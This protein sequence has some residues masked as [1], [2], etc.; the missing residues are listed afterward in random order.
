MLS[1]VLVKEVKVSLRKTR[2]AI[3]LI[4]FLGAGFLATW[5]LWP[6]EGI[7]TLSAQSSHNLFTVLAMG[8]LA[9]VALFAPAF[10]A[11]ALTVEKERNTLEGLYAT[12]LTS[13]DIVLGK[14]GGSLTFLLLVILAGVPVTSTCL[15]LGGV[16]TADVVWMYAIIFLTAL[17]YGLLGLML[18]SLCN[19]TQRA[20]MLTYVLI[21]VLS[22]ATVVPAVLLLSRAG[23][24]WG[25]V[26]R[27][28]S[29]AS[30]F[31]VMASVIEPA[32]LHGGLGTTART[33]VWAFSFWSLGV[34]AAVVGA[35][36]VRL[37]TP[38]VPRPRVDEESGHAS[39]LNRFKRFPFRLIDPSKRRRMI[40]PLSNPVFVKELRTMIFGRLHYLVRAVYM[41]VAVS[42][43]LALGA[44][45]S[46]EFVTT[47]AIAI[48]AVSLQSVLFLFVGP[49]LSATLISS[50]IEGER[51]DLLRLTRLS[52][53]R[54]VSGKFQ[55]ALLPL[56]ILLVA[57]LPPY[58]L[59]A[60][61]DPMLDMQ[62]VIIRTGL[63]MLCMLLFIV[64]AG[65]FFSAVGRRSSFSIAATYVVVVIICV[66]GLIGLFRLDSFSHPVL[67][68]MFVINPIVTVLSEVALPAVRGRFDLWQSNL[69]FLL[70]GSGILLLLT[71]LR[72]S[73]LLRPEE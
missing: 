29:S 64:S 48:L 15:L 9:L 21:I 39:F 49:V 4:V 47:Q 46:Y 18:S 33:E 26:L 32:L 40:G 51:F 62:M 23:P 31:A 42:L 56:A 65:M 60:K 7:Y 8:Q 53:W 41:C 1:P 12:R 44:A 67:Y 45:L 36:A 52:G 71:V 11:P 72:V 59:L 28:L 13:A 22:V 5:M 35:L 30:P 27:L 73:M 6:Q 54:I 16:S 38:P 20:V 55:A 19:K 34:S 17:H 24:S 10:T 70:V 69:V 2:A 14:I 43:A 63:T 68:A 37:S 66:L 58:F 57:T 3:L 50:E 25:G 61:I